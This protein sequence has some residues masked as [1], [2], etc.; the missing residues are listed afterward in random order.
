MDRPGR[1]W[2]LVAHRSRLGTGRTP[3]I[4][5]LQPLESFPPQTYFEGIQSTQCHYPPPG[6]PCS[7][8]G[9]L[10][11]T[12]PCPSFPWCTCTQKHL[13]TAPGTLDRPGKTF[14]EDCRGRRDRECISWG[15]SGKCTLL[16]D[17][18]RYSTARQW[19]CNY[20]VTPGLTVQSPGRHR[21]AETARESRRSPHSKSRRPGRD[22]G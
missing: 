10:R 8:T 22:I 18:G 4:L 20:T 9:A 7:G 5:S 16:A 11:P 13:A 21:K 1:R 6:L 14:R 19:Q 17:T 2:I 15:K 3:W 12:A